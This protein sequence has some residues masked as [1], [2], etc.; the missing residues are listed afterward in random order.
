M[1]K[2]YISLINY[3]IFYGWHFKL[4][5]L[6]LRLPKLP[7]SHFLAPSVS[8]SRQIGWKQVMCRARDIFSPKSP[9]LPLCTNLKYMLHFKWFRYLTPHA[10][11]PT[12]DLVFR[13]NRLTSSCWQPPKVAS[14][15]ADDAFQS[16]SSEE[17]TGR[18]IPAA[19]KG[20]HRFRLC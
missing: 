4:S 2:I 10:P 11:R 16:S 19:P 13:W 8:L 7:T 14:P 1:G 15:H 12:F 9:K 18:R 6:A 5:T 17:D 20:R 3:H